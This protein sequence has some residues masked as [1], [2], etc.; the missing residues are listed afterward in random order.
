MLEDSAIT[1]L[2]S[3][4]VLN[5]THQ[6]YTLLLPF[7]SA[8]Q[9][10]DRK[11][12]LE[13]KACLQDI[14]DIVS[15]AAYLNVCMRVS[16]TIIHIRSETPGDEYD[17]DDQF[18]IDHD[19]YQTSKDQ[20]AMYQAVRHKRAQ[21]VGKIYREQFYGP[22]IKIAV[23]P[24]FKRFNP[25]DGKQGGERRG[26]RVCDISKAGVVYYW[27]RERANRSDATF[28]QYVARE[29]GVGNWLTRTLASIRIPFFDL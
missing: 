21:D 18:N 13:K 22:A 11:I 20:V 17:E 19:V 1:P 6:I 29:K 14:Y 27:A 2:F 16:K 10:T 9:S 5:L 3:P 26:F 12:T 15:R 24:S 8:L 28:G 23:W 25:G 7:H 4:S